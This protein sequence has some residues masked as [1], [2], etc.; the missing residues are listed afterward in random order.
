MIIS[1]SVVQQVL[2]VGAGPAGLAAAIELGRRGIRCCLIERNDRVGVAPRAKT[3]HL[4]TR[5]HLRRWGIAD[6]LAAASPLG[7]EYPSNVIFATRLAGYELARFENSFRC[8]PVPDERY[9]EHAQWVPQY[10]LEEVLRNYAQS[11]PG[12]SIRFE[13]Q[14]ET[15]TQ[16]ASGVQAQVR[17]L[18]DG[19]LITMN[20]DY[21]IGADGG[22]SRV[23]EL[24]GA[25]LAGQK[26]LS[27]NYN[28]IFRA[29]GL[30]Q[31]HALGPAVMYWLV[32]PDLPGLTGPMDTGDRWFF[33]PT[34][35][36]DD[37]TVELEQVP[38]M[39][40]LATGIDLPFE[41]LSADQWTASS[42][43]ADK[44]S[45]GRAF[46]IG[47]ACHLHP[48]MGG[49]GMNMGFGDG[50][51]LGWKLAAVLQGWAAPALLQTY[52]TE[53]KPVH[54]YVIAEAVANHA[55]LG[56]E[57]WREGLEDADERGAQ[58]RA[59]LG[60][61][62][63]QAKQR[64][65][66]APGVIKGYAY[67]SSAIIY[68]DKDSDSGIDSGSGIGADAVD[69]PKTPTPDWREYRPSARPGSVAPHAWL[70][71]DRSLY[72]EFGE[73]FTLLCLDSSAARGI[74]AAATDSTQIGVA[75][76]SAAAQRA[77]IPLK[78]LTPGLAV[79]RERYQARFALIRP[80]QHVAWRGDH[81][82]QSI[83]A[84]FDTLWAPLTARRV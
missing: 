15:F 36:A 16:E 65:F 32:N 52:V 39:L 19:Q 64:E 20:A 25:Q 68:G 63:V 17:D 58:V 11:L 42:L 7:I 13:H 75:A 48:P 84:A 61:A 47:D 21:L 73:G 3:T 81:L 37:F 40:R 60:Q 54:E 57:L 31:A 62:I 12:V 72:D 78:V 34:G 69:E 53:R 66:Q 26:K 2:I 43:V 35:V 82:P 22:R 5:E 56:R 14:L 83:A 4:R 49:Y 59:A 1:Q 50:V 41:A 51:D 10:V 70:A 45:E 23:R 67:R 29:P 6:R 8:S 74:A 30:A 33:M 79:L 46:L 80:D 71:P 9:A 38:A 44:Y 77:G 18:R 76:L 27:R 24:I 28:I 55:V